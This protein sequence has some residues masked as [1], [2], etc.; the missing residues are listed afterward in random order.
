MPESPPKRIFRLLR[1]LTD[2]LLAPLREALIDFNGLSLS[3]RILAVLGYA[4]V[5]VLLAVTLLL[6]L[7]R[8][9]LVVV[10]YTHP[11]V[12]VTVQQI[13]FLVL[14]V[15]AFCFVL[16]WA[17]VLTGATDSGRRVFLPIAGLF[18][19]QLFLFLPQGDAGMFMWFCAAPPL[20]LGLIVAHFF[21][22][23]KRYCR[24]FPL[25][26]FCLWFCVLL[27]FVALFWLSRQSTEHVAQTIGASFDILSLLN[28]P[29]WLFFGLATVDLAVSVGH[30]IVTT[31]RKLL[32]DPV[33]HAL[34]VFLVLARPAIAI[35]TLALDQLD[36]ILGG[37][38]FL[39]AILSTLPLL[40][41]TIGAAL[42]RRWNTRTATTIIALGIVSPVFILCVFPVLTGQE[43]FDPMGAALESVA[44]L[45]PLLIFVALM[46]HSV[47]SL[48]SAFANK[49]GQIIPRSGRVLLGFGFALL[50]IG[51]TVFSV[52]V[53]DAAG[54]L[55]QT[56]QEATDAFFG[57]SVFILGLPY[58][59][60][61]VWRRRDRLVGS[62]AEFEGMQP[63]F[64]GLARISGRRWLVVG[65]T[66]A[67]LLACIA[68][69]AGIF[70]FNPPP[71]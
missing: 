28:V 66:A 36:T 6:D 57:L 23:S 4:S 40:A 15:S 43:I 29:L 5:A 10:T 46:A 58:L 64:A 38:L 25:V 14:V 60:W 49:D 9:R 30:G 24:D 62:E 51:L 59:L 21:T 3:L 13:P 20:I 47:L 11:G 45:P 68:C 61:I 34:A 70:L 44:V 27:F 16:G 63:V 12:E 37:T 67:V 50:V 26:E 7:L 55:D 54:Q 56:F 53:R 71:Q 17:Y 22:Q 42:L 69:L 19:V 33:L 31:L 32:P 2:Y 65:I 18:A 1:Q 52:N 41:L 35:V 8:D 48:G 39:D